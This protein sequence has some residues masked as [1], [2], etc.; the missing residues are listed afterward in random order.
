MIKNIDIQDYRL[1]DKTRLQPAPGLTVIT[2]ETGAGKSMLMGAI[3]LTT[4][5]RAEANMVRETTPKCIIEITH[6]LA[7]HDLQD[8]FA[9][10]ELDYEPE[11]LIRREIT[12]EG[13]SRAF[14]NDTP[15][16]GRTLRELGQRLIDIHSQHQAL[17]VGETAFQLDALD[18]FCGNTPQR[19]TYAATYHQ[20]EALRH[21]LDEEQRLANE[22]AREEDYLRFQFNQLDEAH[23]R[24]GEDEELEAELKLL[25]NAEL[26]RRVLGETAE[27][28]RGGDNSVTRLLRVLRGRLQGIAPLVAEASDAAERLNS[29]IIELEDIAEEA[30]RRADQTEADPRRE[31]VARERLDT[32][33]DLQRKHRVDG[34]LALLLLRDHLRER[35]ANITSRAGKIEE[36]QTRLARLDT[37]LT[38][39]AQQLHQVRLAGKGRLEHEMEQLLRELGIRHATFQV[40]ITPTATFR[41]TGTDNARFLFAANKNQA[42]GELAR[43]A[44]GGET[45]RVMLALKY[46]LSR[47]KLLPVIIFDEIDTGVSGETA[48][49]VAAI[50]RDMARRMQVI[51]ITHLP[52]IAAAGDVHYKIYKDDTGTGTLSRARRLDDDERV[53][54]LA[55]MMSGSQITDA[56]KENARRLIADFRA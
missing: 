48:H 6:E 53:E 37:Q 19:E 25:E 34:T 51:C 32:L 9:E 56:A 52:Q 1:I 40:E 12:R 18:A 45:S 54:E 43:V 27:T 26:I 20:R 41:P 17:L 7:K 14:I 44:S 38:A 8:W 11:T 33:Y 5:E 16:N 13:R 15:V 46:I 4:G 39:Q 2:G 28:L 50:L 10:H 22:E 30:E 3:G 31:T 29:V 36:L 47:V 35:L 21:Q 55:A 42:P 24:E 23:L 49:R